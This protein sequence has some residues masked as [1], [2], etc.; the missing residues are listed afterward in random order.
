MM[1]KLFR[2]TLKTSSLQPPDPFLPSLVPIAHIRVFNLFHFPPCH[3]LSGLIS[4]SYCEFVGESLLPASWLL[5][6]LDCWCSWRRFSKGTIDKERQ[7]AMS[8]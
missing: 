1:F 6:S 4:H 8:K 5:A 2:P 3:F 7:K